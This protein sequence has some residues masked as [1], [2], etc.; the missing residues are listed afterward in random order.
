MPYVN[1]RGVGHYYEWIKQPS[2]ER[3]KSVMVFVH[4][5]AGSARYWR[6]TAEALSEQFDCLLYDMRGFGRS[7]G[8]PNLQQAGEAVVESKSPQEQAEALTELSY[9]LTAYA[10][11]LA[12]LLDKLSIERVYVH[13]HS[14]GASVA[15]LFLN[16]Y[17]QQVEKGILTC[18]GVFEYD[19][20]A[21]AAF[22]RFGGY[23]VKFRPKWLVKIPFVDRLF[24]AR[25]LHRQIPK[26]ERKAFLQDFL[27][28]DYDAALGTIFTSV[29][30][31]QAELMPQEFAKLNVPTLLI[32]GEHDQIIPAQMGQ[33]AAAL[34]E[35]V[36]FTV[37]PHTAHFPMLE[38]PETYLSRIKGFLNN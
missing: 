35:Q 23:A 15:T 12:A 32:A 24:M 1:V 10:E 17:S 16:R 25:F 38:D 29:S 28:A 19:E 26:S 20:Q 34:S 18:S 2:P 6:S 21:F 22:Y 7:Q 33:K 27:D 4:G 3:V 31:A 36:E 9:E 5:W 8:Q 30:Q 37:I 11:D 13:A 14:M